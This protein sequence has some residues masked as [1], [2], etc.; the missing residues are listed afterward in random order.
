MSVGVHKLV[1]NTRELLCRLFKIEDPSR[2]I[3]TLNATDALN[4]AIKGLLKPGDHAITTSMEHNSVSRP[5]HGLSLKG[6]NVTKIQCSSDGTLSLDEIEMAIR[7]N[8]RAIIM[9]HASNVTGTLMPV[10]EIGE[11]ARKK[12]IIFVVDAAQTA[13]I[14]DINLSKTNIDLLIAPGHKGLM[15]PPGTG[16][17]VLA[18]NVELVPLREGG[19]GSHSEVP[20]Q[21][22]I[23]PEKYESG[24]LI[25]W[26]C[27]FGGKFKMDFRYWN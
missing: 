12:G 7:Q 5:L 16:V 25:R 15:G 14:F 20:G 23:L 4:M 10:E 1:Q 22:D 24:T 17:L 6:V 8:T 26:H 21:P 19:T 11:I 18:S 2:I 13:G 3:F 9:L 27:R